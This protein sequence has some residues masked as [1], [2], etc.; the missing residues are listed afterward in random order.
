MKKNVIFVGAFLLF[1]SGLASGQV[2]PRGRFDDYTI[3]GRILFSNG[4]DI[5]ERLEVRLEKNA[6]Q[7]IATA[8]TDSVGNFEFRNLQPGMY[9]VSVSA[10]GYEEVRQSVDLY[11]S[12]NGSTSI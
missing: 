7:V 8:Y 10:D 5:G 11:T 4:H 1:L 2:R 3:R 12:V 6:L 9:F